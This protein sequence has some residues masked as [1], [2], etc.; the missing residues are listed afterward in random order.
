MADLRI[1]VRRK[2][3]GTVS[4]GISISSDSLKTK[5]THRG[6]ST[7]IK[8]RWGDWPE[9]QAKEVPTG[10]PGDMEEAPARAPSDIEEAR[11]D[12]EMTNLLGF[13]GGSG[14]TWP[15]SPH[16]FLHY[17]FLIS[18][19]LTFFCYCLYCCWHYYFMFLFI[20]L[21]TLLSLLF[22]SVRNFWRH[23]SQLFRHRFCD[24]P[25]SCVSRS[26]CG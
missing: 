5:N 14:A 22:V 24:L 20:W 16:F 7:M 21:L 1:V 6:L 4:L 18:L 12:E 19:L 10:A 23:G 9:A 26:P 15:R 25:F 13:L 2:R 11:M 17:C 3:N 8:G